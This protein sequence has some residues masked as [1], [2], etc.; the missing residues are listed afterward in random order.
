M[1]PV[2][3]P[4]LG[5][6]L[7]DG[8]CGIDMPPEDHIKTARPLVGRSSHVRMGGPWRRGPNETGPAKARHGEAPL[9]THDQGSVGAVS[10]VQSPLEQ[11]T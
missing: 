11:L 3:P 7:R 5:A 1:G 4:E 8:R 10:T 2:N 9:A 6:N